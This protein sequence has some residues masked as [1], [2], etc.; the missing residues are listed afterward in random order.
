MCERKD[1]EI[2]ARR[3]NLLKKLFKDSKPTAEALN[4]ILD[5]HPFEVTTGDEDIEG[6]VVKKQ[7]RLNA[8]IQRLLD[9]ENDWK[10]AC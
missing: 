10:L 6:P 5:K 2:I 3:L 1:R 8:F 9:S 7:N 4:E